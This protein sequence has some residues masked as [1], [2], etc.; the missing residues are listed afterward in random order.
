MNS[1]VNKLIVLKL[2]KSWQAVGYSTVQKAIVDL[3]AG[4][5]ARALDLTYEMDADGNPTGDP[6]GMTPVDWETWITLPVRPY[7]L[8][9]SYA[10][11]TKLLRVP[12]VLIATNFNKMPVKKFRGKPSKDAIWHRDGGIDQYTGK[13][14]RREDATIDHV[15]PQSKG[16]GDTWENLVT[17][18]R[19]INSEKG[20]K[21]NNEA[22]LTLIRSPK[23]PAPVPLNMLINEVR[24]RDWAPFIIKKK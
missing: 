14:L 10:G 18:H 9:V 21:L 5:S 23:A 24:H 8:S 12:T 22:G 19:D 2:N 17:T 3:A 1:V 15:L 4:V 11:G 13:P 7:D 6:I 16:G 20:N